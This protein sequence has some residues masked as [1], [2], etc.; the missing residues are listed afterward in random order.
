MSKIWLVI[1]IIVVVVI[2][3]FWF[4]RSGSPGADQ[5]DG[6]LTML[7]PALLILEEQN[8]SGITGTVAFGD[9]NGSTRVVAALEGAAEGSI[10]P[11]HIHAGACPA[12]GAVKFPL[13]SSSDGFSET[14]L[15]V[16]LS[17]LMGS[18]PLAVNVHKSAEEA[19]IYVACGDITLD[20]LLD[21]SEMISDDAIPE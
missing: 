4:R 16:S 12:P 2:A 11:M 3:A 21:A 15:N 19:S 1:A 14:V 5:G 13:A 20:S 10:Q 17:D 8:E 6:D 7:A 9:E 18:L